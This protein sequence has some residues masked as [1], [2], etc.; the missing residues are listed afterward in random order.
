M[1]SEIDRLVRMLEKTF[2]KQPWYGNSIVQTI[3]D[4]HPSITTLR[5]GP[6]NNIIELILHITSWRLYVI[7]KLMGDLDFVMT[8]EL[9]FPKSDNWELAVSNLRTSQQELI[10]SLKSFPESRLDEL[11]PGASHKYTFYTLINGIIQH[12]IYH[13]GQIA[14]I[15]KSFS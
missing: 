14:Y 7:K 1:A 15:K 3:S 6:T 11:V 5:H 8:D 13:L 2:D 4:I 12:D 10:E 9:N